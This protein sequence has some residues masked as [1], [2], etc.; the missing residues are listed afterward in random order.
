MRDRD[1]GPGQS[2]L[3]MG[4]TVSLGLALCNEVLQGSALRRPGSPA[5]AVKSSVGLALLPS[6]MASFGWVFRT[7]RMILP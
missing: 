3:P 1:Q 5:R 4:L 2:L 6:L 7:L